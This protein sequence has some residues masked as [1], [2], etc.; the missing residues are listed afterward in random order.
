MNEIAFQFSLPALQHT[1]PWRTPREIA[2]ECIYST[3]VLWRMRMNFY[4]KEGRDISLGL[5]WRWTGGQWLLVGAQMSW[6]DDRVRIWWPPCIGILACV[7]IKIAKREV[8]LTQFVV[9]TSFC[10]CPWINC[11]AESTVTNLSSIIIAWHR[12]I[13]SLSILIKAHFLAL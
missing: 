11:R 13:I 9:L 3:W 2:S 10:E 5:D 8:S 7:G 4:R 6:N 12:I 1:G